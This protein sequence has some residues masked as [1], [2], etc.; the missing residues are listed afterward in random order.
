MNP[1]DHTYHTP[2]EK[3]VFIDPADPATAKLLKGLAPN[4]V[5]SLLTREAREWAQ[6]QLREGRAVRVSYAAAVWPPPVPGD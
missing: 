5:L 2:V 6:K 4:V 1:R 3:V